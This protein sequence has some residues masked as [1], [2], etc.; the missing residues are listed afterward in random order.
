MSRNASL[1]QQRN[2][3]FRD[4]ENS[5]QSFVSQHKTH[6][7]RLPTRSGTENGHALLCGIGTILHHESTSGHKDRLPMKKLC[8]TS[9]THPQTQAGMLLI[10]M[11]KTEH[12]CCSSGS[13]YTLLPPSQSELGTDSLTPQITL[14]PSCAISNW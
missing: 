13:F 8:N 3:P 14:V 6:A 2:A 4:V 1:E 11:N 12:M 10:S 5:A 9:G 7:S